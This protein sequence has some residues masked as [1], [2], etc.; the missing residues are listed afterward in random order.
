MSL[1]LATGL[2]LAHAA[3]DGSAPQNGQPSAEETVNKLMLQTDGVG[4]G[5]AD[6]GPTRP[7]VLPADQ[8]KKPEGPAD[9]DGTRL[10]LADEEPGNWMTTGRTYFEQHYSA[11]DRINAGNV[12]RLGLAWHYDFKDRYGQGA[13]P[14][15]VDGVMYL[16]SAL[17]KVTAFDAKTGKLLWSY[18]PKVPGQT[19]IDAGGNWLNRGVAVGEGRVFVTTL[20]GRLIS[21]DAVT[22]KL[23][24]EVQTT[25][26]A[27]P[28]TMT[29]APRLIQGMLVIGNS[30]TERGVRGYVSAYNVFSGVRVWRYYTVPG[31]P[32]NGKDAQIS[33]QIMAQVAGPTWH[34]E[35]WRLGGGGA[36]G[37]AIAYDSKL[38]LIYIGVGAGSPWNPELRSPGGGDNFFLS[39]IVAIRPETGEYVWFYQAM[40]HDE[41]GYGADQQIILADLPIDGRMRKVMMQASKN[42]Y[43][44]VIDRATGIFISAVPYTKVNWASSIDPMTGHP[45]INP[46]AE[47]TKT[48]KPTYVMPGP[49]GGHD[50]QIM[51]FSPKTGLVYIPAQ[52]TGFVYEAVPDEKK[53]DLGLNMGIRFEN[54]PIPEGQGPGN[55]KVPDGYLLAWNP[56]T[57]KEV[58]RVPYGRAWNGGVLSTGGNLVVEGTAA[59]DLNVYAADTGKTLWSQP[60]ESGVTGAPMTYEV[61]GEQYIAVPVGWGGAWAAQHASGQ[62][63]NVNRLLVYKLDGKDKLPPAPTAEKRAALTPPAQSGT[64]ETIARGKT[65][66]HRYCASCHGLDAKAGATFPDLRYSQTLGTDGWASATHHP[67]LAGGMTFASE[68]KDD[69]LSAIRDYVISQAR[70]AKE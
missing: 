5:P 17:S 59:G 37:N 55:V 65:V 6:V 67:T 27:M 34:G 15:V 46:E 29:G 14:I 2:P 51:S 56:V 62:E 36:V 52:Q 23:L 33:D 50:G 25:D 60:V 68:L 41:W 57:Q 54:L 9:V 28:Y 53:S 32:K 7:D 47:Y 61:D 8:R 22:G 20:D 30:G 70:M 4:A 10:V 31:D 40:P 44:Y 49:F 48:G 58:W 64:P 43:F 3:D 63:E 1:A 16:S 11:L 35:F 69:D 13:T 24:W 21:L 38:D 45:V 19:L 66:Y 42:G 18:D 26:P 12:N 39:S